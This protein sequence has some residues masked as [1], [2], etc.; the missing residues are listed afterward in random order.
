MLYNEYGDIRLLN[1][2]CAV[3]FIFQKPRRLNREW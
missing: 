3:D 1:A 2:D